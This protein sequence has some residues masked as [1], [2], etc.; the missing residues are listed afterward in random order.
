MLFLKEAKTNLL[1]NY[2]THM[3]LIR[4]GLSKMVLTVKELIE[5][6]SISIASIGKKN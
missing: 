5:M 1:K 4:V 3:D 2:A 6:D